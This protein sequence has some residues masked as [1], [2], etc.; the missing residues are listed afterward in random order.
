MEI[1]VFQF[2]RGAKRDRGW[3]VGIEPELQNTGPDHVQM[4]IGVIEHGAAVAAM[5]QRE[6]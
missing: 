4:H 6:R 2:H 3:L 1:T 5:A